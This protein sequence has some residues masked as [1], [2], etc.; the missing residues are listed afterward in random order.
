MIR[1]KKDKSLLK[2][3]CAYVL[4][5]IM[6]VTSVP[7]LGA[8]K[9]FAAG[10][11]APTITKAFIETNTISGGNLHR[12]KINGKNVRGT[13]HVTLKDSS[14][15]EKAT[16]SVTPKSGTTWTVKLPEGVTI[17]EGD[18]VTAYQEFDGQQSTVTTANAQPSKAYENKEKLKMPTGEIWIENTSSNLVNEDEQ[19]EAVKMLKDANTEIAGDIKS[20][21]FSIDG[22]DHAYYEV[23]YTDESTSG[24][25]EATGLE[26]K[27]VTETSIGANLESITVVDNVIKGKLEGNGPFDNIKVQLILKVNDADK[28]KFCNDK[29]SLDKN[30][31]KPVEVNLDSETGKFTYNIKSTDK[32]ELGNIVGVIVKE[33]N[34]FQNCSSKKTVTLTTPEKTAVKDPRDLTDK[35]KK[36]IDEAIREANTVD[37]K[38]KLPDGTGF[39]NDPAF[40]EFDKDGNARIISPNDVEVEWDEN[41]KP[42]YQKNADGS[43]KLQEDKEANVITIPAK[44]LVK[45]Y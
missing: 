14:G 9:V 30:S 43:Y 18:T 32:I 1:I 35:D 34:K 19:A 39:I 11:E 5:F 24:K 8:G 17:A 15:T 7:G 37:E 29:C 33:K 45:E 41:Y 26:I 3:F 12:G 25:V 13:I 23:T 10:I 38:S 28:S 40:I 2:V 6:L 31:S 20:V 44:D 21:K 4:A 16:V 42:V 22:T 27:Q 36:A